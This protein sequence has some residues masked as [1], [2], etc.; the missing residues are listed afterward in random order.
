MRLIEI[1]YHQTNSFS[2]FILDYISGDK[3]LIPFYNRYPKLENFKQQILEKQKQ[4]LNRQ[5]LV[6]ALNQQYSELETSHLVKDNIQS[7]AKENT[8]TV[9]TGHQL[10]LFAG[11]LYFIYKIISTLNLSESLKVAY[12]EY[13]FVPVYWMATEDHD[14]EEVNHV[15]LFGKKLEW[16]QDQNGG[17]GAISTKSLDSVLEE[18]KPILGDSENA[19]EIYTLLSEAYLNNSTFASATR[20]LVNALFSKY[21]LVVLDAD[22]KSLKQQAIP[23]IKKDVLEQ[24]NYTLIESTNAELSKTQAFVRPINFFYQQ[25][26]GRN[27]I[28]LQGGEYVV[29]NTNLKFTRSELEK[30]IESHPERFSPNVLLRPLYKE[31]ILPNLAMIGGGAEVNYWMQLKSTFAA[32]EIVYPILMLRN[33]AMI[34]DRKSSGKIEKLGFK[35]SDFFANEEELH[36]SFVSRNIQSVVDLSSELKQLDSLYDSLLSKTD[37]MGMQSSM[38]AEK[39]KQQNVLKRIEQKLLKAEKQKHSISLNQISQVKSKLFPNGSLQ[40]RHDNIIPFYLRYGN[41]FI[42][43]LKESLKP[44]DHAFSIL[45]ED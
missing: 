19:K 41:S 23:L 5:V 18:L 16:N 20:S 14:F 34:I 9:A 13:N 45:I 25:K 26:G 39:H 2:K 21:G 12:P 43:N 38:L 35:I 3:S 28:E 11:P 4:P 22:E 27:R 10:C 24:A 1:P 37:E 33:S 7:L 31:L 29:L 42:D 6:A 15:Y 36:K 8:F 17:V 40:E 44:I 30:E 32:N